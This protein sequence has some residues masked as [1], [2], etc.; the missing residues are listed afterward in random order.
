MTTD[1]DV[2]ILGA[3][4]TGLYSMYKFRDEMGLRVMGFDPAEGPGGVWHWNRYPGARCDFPSIYYSFRFSREVA[5]E[6]KWSQKYAAQPEIEAYMNFV[7]DRL[8]LR[9]SFEFGVG[10]KSVAWDDANSCWRA[11]MTDGREIS[12]RFLMAGTGGLSIPAEVK[13]PGQEK[14]AGEFYATSSY[15]KNLTDFSGKRVGVIGTGSSGIQTIQEVSK[16]ADHL[17]VFQ[18]T[19]QYATPMRNKAMSPEEQ[20]WNCENLD[21][22]Y[23]RAS[24]IAG[25]DFGEMRPSL[26]AEDPAEVQRHLEERYAQ[27]GMGFAFMNYADVLYDPRAN[28]VVSEFIRNKIRERVKDPKTAEMLCPK[29]YPYTTKRPPLETN[30]FEVYNQPNVDLVDIRATP[31]VEFT[32]K[33]IRTSEGEVELDVVI[34]ATGFDA[35]T[36][37][38]LALPMTGRNGATLQKYWDDGPLA[39]MGMFIHDF[40][41]YFQIGVGPSAASQRNAVWFNEEQIDLAAAA[42]AEVIKRDAKTIEPT[43]Q[44]DRDWKT[45]CDGLLPF[46]LFPLNKNT[47]YLGHNVEGKKPVAYVFFAGAPLYLTIAG[48]IEHG[49][50]GGFAIDGEAQGP[51]PSLVRLNPGVANFVGAMMMAG[52]P[53]LEVTPLEVMRGMVAGQGAMQVPGPDMTVTDVPDARVRVYRPD[54]AEPLPVIIAMHGGGFV[55]GNLETLDPTCRRL[56][57]EVGAIVVNLDYRL[58]PEHPHPAAVNDTVDVVTWVRENIAEFGGDPTRIALLGESA[59]ANLA[60]VASRRHGEAGTGV[61]AQ[62]L[63]Y[64]VV[65]GEIDTPSKHEFMFGPFLSIAAAD[66]FWK[67]YMQ[68]QPNTADASPLRATNLGDSPSTLLVTMGSDPLRDEGELYVAKLREAGA[69]VE[70]ERFDGLMHATYTFS[71]MIPAAQSIHERIVAFLKKELS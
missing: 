37:A 32:E 17:T 24:H 69:D 46:T 64:P 7:A 8:D 52:A 34:A 16:S 5:S 57:A 68:G 61:T 19:P 55:A 63:L 26:L 50:W 60:A 9:R 62:V 42:V 49:G 28:E 18:R 33:G 22:V 15:P 2:L 38:Q 27:G 25:A 44:A 71:A 47:W 13:F 70:H 3:G 39:Y 48:A 36:G 31:I 59:G 20:A 10:A 12:A 58:A 6:W 53:P 21:E 29:D 51:T 56:A 43:A 41:N 11:R 65:D 67:E 30:Y 4:F 40:P 54:S 66:R 23:A 14:F 1:T 35:F 45:L